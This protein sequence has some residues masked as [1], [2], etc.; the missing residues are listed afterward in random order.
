MQHVA[1]FGCAPRGRRIVLRADSLFRQRP[2]LWIV[3]EIVVERAVERAT[4]R[5]ELGQLRD[6]V[7]IECL[8]QVDQLDQPLLLGC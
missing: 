6:D 1:A 4:C 5:R 2:G 7:L 3:R 8:A